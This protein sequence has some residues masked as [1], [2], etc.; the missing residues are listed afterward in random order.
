[1]SESIIVVGNSN[2]TGSSDSKRAL[3]LTTILVI[4]GYVGVEVEA[5]LE[6]SK[7]TEV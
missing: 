7:Q 3:G 2:P 4:F 1:M 6:I 5:A